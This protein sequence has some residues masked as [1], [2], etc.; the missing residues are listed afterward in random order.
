MLAYAGVCWRVLTYAGG[1]WRMLTF[2]DVCWRML[3]YIIASYAGVCWRML[4]YAGF[5]CWRMLTYADVSDTRLSRVLSVTPLT[6]SLL[7]ASHVCFL[8]IYAPGRADT[9]YLSSSSSAAYRLIRSSSD[10]CSSYVSVCIRQHTSD[11][12]CLCAAGRTSSLSNLQSTVDSAA[13]CWRMLTYA[14]V[15]WF[16]C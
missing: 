16:N 5:A 1:C 14:D 2:A 8:T 11:V 3:A 12:S 4:T 10:S 9:S 15:C 13:V 6:C 7:H